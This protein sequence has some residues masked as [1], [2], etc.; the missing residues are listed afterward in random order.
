MHTRNGGGPV[1]RLD[2]RGKPVDIVWSE[3]QSPSM[4][5]ATRGTLCSVV[6]RGCSVDEIAE[7]GHEC[8]QQR[9]RNERAETI[10]DDNYRRSLFGML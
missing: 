2:E 3:W 6:V 4:R 10:A 9:R 7:I 8:A 1:L 5:N